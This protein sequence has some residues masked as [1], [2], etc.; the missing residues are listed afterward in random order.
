MPGWVRVAQGCD[1]RKC[2]PVLLE[3][4]HG[5]AGVEDHLAHD[6]RETGA[7]VIIHSVGNDRYWIN[8]NSLVSLEF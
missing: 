4:V 6:G 2:D 3:P 7:V 1:R 5:F 8:L